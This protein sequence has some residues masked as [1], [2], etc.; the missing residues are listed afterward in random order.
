[1]CLVPL[2]LVAAAL[3]VLSRIGIAADALIR[4]AEI[5]VRIA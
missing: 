5:I 4:F 3:L 1:M 2:G